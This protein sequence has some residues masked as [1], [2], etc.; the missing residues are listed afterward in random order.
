MKVILNNPTERLAERILE[1]ISSVT[2]IFADRGSAL[3]M[4]RRH[5]PARRQ[6]APIQLTRQFRALLEAAAESRFDERLLRHLA[7]NN[8]KFSQM[9]YEDQL[10]QTKRA[11]SAADF[12]G[13]R[14]EASVAKFARIHLAVPESSFASQTV[15]NI[16][17]SARH[18]LDRVK[19]LAR[20]FRVDI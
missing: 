9:S 16:V 13:F 5:A 11:I 7:R 18:E 8:L 6:N 17:T 4:R 19:D 20:Y 12:Y 1:P 15:R 10:T 3:H 2:T 14:I